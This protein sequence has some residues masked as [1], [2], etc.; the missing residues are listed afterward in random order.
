M[1]KCEPPPH[2][3]GIH[4]LRGIVVKKIG[5]PMFNVTAVSGSNNSTPSDPNRVIKIDFKPREVIRFS[6]DEMYIKG[7]S[8]K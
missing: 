2:S 4:L 1:N 5:G 6:V 7:A 3:R 8:Y